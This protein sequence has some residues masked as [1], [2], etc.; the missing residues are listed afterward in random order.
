MVDIL[1]ALDSLRISTILK[2]LICKMT[3]LSNFSY[4]I[5]ALFKILIP[6]YVLQKAKIFAFCFLSY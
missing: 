3:N 5:F 1:A 4:I 2:W 6:I